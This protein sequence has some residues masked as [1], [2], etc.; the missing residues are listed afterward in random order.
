MIARPTWIERLHESWRKAPIAWL[1]GV[2]R[3]GKTTLTQQLSGIHYLNCDL[4]SVRDLLQDPERL[5]ASVRERVVV[6]DEVHRLDD[7]SAVLKIAADAFPQLRIVASGSST[8]AATAKFRDTLTGRKREVHLVPVLYAEL[9][10]FGITDLKT[11]L[12]HGGLP[13]LLLAPALDPEAYSEWLASFYARDVQELF[14]VEKRTAFLRFCELLLRQS[15][16]MFEV[17]SLARDAAISRPTV[18]SWRDILETTHL[19]T[20]VR[21]HHGGAMREI[22]AQPKVYAFDTGFVCH[23]RRWDALREDD[24]GV[25]WEHVVLETLQSIPLLDIRFWRDKSKHELDFVLPRARDACD[26]IEC[27]WRPGTFK[28]KNLAVFREAYPTGRNFVVSPRRTPPI[29]RSE[30]GLEVTHVGLE[31]LQALL[32]HPKGS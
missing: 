13:A 15:G 28:P 10:A 23:A 24:L 29:T 5:F 21:P 12:L 2:R 26:V 1:S 14:R 30:G 17:A 31:Q 16:G 18:M 19:I 22:V 8:I 4:P 6:L 32:S 11:R 3:V 27:K 25:L 9:S 7:P 20:T